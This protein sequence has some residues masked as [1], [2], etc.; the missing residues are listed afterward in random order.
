MFESL[1]ANGRVRNV[2]KFLMDERQIIVKGPLSGLAK[3][4]ARRDRVVGDL[5][6]G[7]IRV[8]EA[9]I[10]RIKREATRNQALL[11]ASLSGIKAAKAQLAAQQQA[12]T[13]MGTYTGTGER[14]QAPQTPDQNDRVI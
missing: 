13:S 11:E 12:A 6:N 4:S 9:D 8:R 2:L 1:I 7:R 10:V 3:L 5:N 14:M